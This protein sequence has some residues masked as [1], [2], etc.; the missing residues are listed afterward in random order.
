VASD[1]Q[2]GADLVALA[3][4]L[5][6]EAHAGT[7]DKAGRD[8]IS[9]PARVA[10]RV[11]PYGPEIVAVAWLHDVME[12][13]GV[14][15]SDLRD[16]GIPQ[17][18]IDGVISLT[19]RPAEAHPEAVERAARNSYGLVVKAADVADNS[20]PERLALLPE[21]SR[22]RLRSKYHHAREILDAHS[23]PRFD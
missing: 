21:Q 3:E 2:Q 4:E 9:H 19:R 10:A 22:E 7:V 15:A 12:D 16:Q 8:Y 5:A 23:A 6:K 17:D 1:S 14:T 20:D 13:C 11:E 18:V